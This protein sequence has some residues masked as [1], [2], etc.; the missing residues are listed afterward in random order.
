MPSLR[1]CT[2]PKNSGAFNLFLLLHFKNN[3][4][5]NINLNINSYFERSSQSK[6][7]RLVW[8]CGYHACPPACDLVS[9]LK[10]LDIYFLIRYGRLTRTDV[11]LL[12][13][14][15]HHEVHFT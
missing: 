3:S 9:T 13:F 4:C 10:L 8:I 14:S 7:E 12:R 1:P 11:R 15:V 5:L 2:Q 6:E